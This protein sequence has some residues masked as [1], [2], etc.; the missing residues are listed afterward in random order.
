MKIFRIM[1]TLRAEARSRTADLP[2]SML[3]SSSGFLLWA[4]VFIMLI[5]TG[6]TACSLFSL[7]ADG[8]AVFGQNLDWHEPIPGVVAVNKRGI[9]KMVLPWKGWWP[10]PREGGTVSWVSRYG[11]VTFTCYGRDFID[12]GMN[13][14]GL[15]VDE[16]SLT[17]VY[18]PDDGRPGVSCT[19]WMQ[20]QLDNFAT[21]DEVLAHL[22]DL[23][24]DGEGWHYLIADSSGHCAVIEYLT[25][26]ALVH[27]GPDVGVCAATNTTHKQALSHMPLDRAFGGDLDIGAGGDSYGRFVR[28]A[29]LMR[30]YEPA[31]HG[32][33][34]A[35]AFHILDL[36]SC[37]DTRRRVVYDAGR[38]RVLWITREN[39]Q[40][41]WLDLDNLHFSGDTPTLMCNVEMGGPG[42]VSHL[43]EE[44]TLEVNR[45]VV[46]AVR[47]SVME[48]TDLTESL[49]TRGLTVEEALELIARHPYGVEE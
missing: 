45:E 5:S 41:R 18:P 21:V 20:Y 7:F 25:G 16:A 29:A 9:A 26:E 36:V 17:A 39:P 46:R 47:G 30:D 1:N 49:G 14:A 2:G 4:L 24:P 31:R 32:D 27:A 19:Q 15:M 38:R 22:D 11:S 8:E 42:E 12:G 28:M 23:R 43:L 13:E 6:S 35:Y 44:Y 10:A 33:A 3:K 34:A 37:T 48:N 40:V